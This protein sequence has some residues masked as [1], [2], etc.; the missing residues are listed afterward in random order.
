MA[1]VP[2]KVNSGAP[3]L[4][5]TGRRSHLG[6]LQTHTS[7]GRLLSPNLSTLSTLVK[8]IITPYKK[9][10]ELTSLITLVL[11]VFAHDSSN[12]G[13]EFD[14]LNYPQMLVTSITSYDIVCIIYSLNTSSS[15]WTAK[16]SFKGL[17]GTISILPLCQR[18]LRIHCKPP[19]YHTTHELGIFFQSSKRV[20]YH[21]I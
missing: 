4:F 6:L 1:R 19:A 7:V 13:P 9:T 14:E 12:N 8:M 21:I 11:A 5:S 3:K 16:V 2:T 15:V 17:R 18:C 20:I 10:L